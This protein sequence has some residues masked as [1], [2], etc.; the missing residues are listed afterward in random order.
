MKVRST[1]KLVIENLENVL[2]RGTNWI[3][4]VI[5]TLPAVA[6]LRETLP[7]A[8][9]S[10][11][12]KPWVAGIYEICSDVDDVIVYWSSDVH[13]GVRGKCRLAGEL[14]KERFDA[15]ILLQN[16]IEAAI[17]TW[18][19][20]IPIRC[21]YNA[22]GRGLLLTHS[23]KRT[24][25]IRKV[26]QINYYLEMMKSLGA[27]WSGEHINITMG[28]DYHLAA[29][30]ILNRQH[31]KSDEIKIGIAPGAAYGPAKMWFAD[32]FAAVAD[33][34]VN[35]FSAHVF[36]FGSRGDQ[37]VA[38]YVQSHAT[39]TLIN[40]AGQTTLKEVIALI[41]QCDLFI[42]NDSG[43][44]HLA[45][46]LDIPVV[47][48]FGST[49]PVTTS[50]VGTRSVI[51]HKEVDCTPCLKKV[52]PTDFKCMDRITIEDVYNASETLLTGKR[53]KRSAMDD[54]PAI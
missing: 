12:A 35:D 4:D 1:K 32:R 52:C 19:A 45:G 9:I 51:V 30:N 21:G 18:L 10:V 43:L 53:F 48:I 54:Q 50:P 40:L 16:A 41:A 27:R 38:Q 37:D 23:V 46:A 28:D 13:A 42:S 29:E 5:M 26:H 34:L 31:I 20:R 24:K 6:A 22:D 36:L 11:L 15:A 8:R 14:R 33:K 49:N 3:G 39:N 7:H 25:E 47:A 2:V 44:M 17:I